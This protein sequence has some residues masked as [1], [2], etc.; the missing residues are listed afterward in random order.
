MGLNDT[1]S[2]L[3]VYT[4]CPPYRGEADY[5]LQTARIARWSERQGCEGILVYTDNTQLDPWMVAQNI[6]AATSTLSPLV[7]VQPVYMHPYTVAKIVTTFAHLYDRRLVL[8]MVAGGFRNDLEALGDTTPHD[9]RY[10]RLVEYTGIIRDLLADEPTSLS[11]EHYTVSQLRLRPSLPET[12]RPR[13]LVSGSSDAGVAAAEAIG[14]TAIRYP[15]PAHEDTQA[16]PAH[17][18]Q[19]I[20][21]GVIAREDADE[22][23]EVART[24]FPEDRRGQIAHRMA[25]KVSDSSWHRTLSERAKQEIPGSPFWLVPFEN[26]KTFCPYLVGDYSTVAQ[27]LERYLSQGCST[28]ILDV[29]DSEEELAHTNRAIAAALSPV[30]R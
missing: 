9:Q 15:A 24:R 6:A 5:L 22:A 2:G 1:G 19:G 13:Y 8:N 16:P 4:T 23:W 29:P 18:D 12:L 7:A 11:G 17:I 25:M 27:E 14:A 21:V 30:A 26:Y 28:L 10:A 3:S 20:R